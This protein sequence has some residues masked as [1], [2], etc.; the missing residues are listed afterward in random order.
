MPRLPLAVLAAFTLCSSLAVA[1]EGVSPGATLTLP[2]CIGKALA[3]HPGIDAARAA[4]DAGAA[5]LRASRAAYYPG[6]SSFA[7]YQR[8][9]RAGAD[10][11]TE[12]ENQYRAGIGASY[13]LLDF[14]RRSE[15]VRASERALAANR[16]ELR[17]YERELTFDVTAAYLEL[18][19]AERERVVTEQS[20]RK[21]QDHLQ[22]AQAFFAAGSKPRYDV[23]KAEIDLVDEQL[24]LTVASNSVAL[25]RV[26]LAELVGL[27]PS[28]DWTVAD[29]AE[30]AAAPAPLADALSSAAASR[31][32]L[33]AANE[34]A[35][36][37]EATL[38]AVRAQHRPVLSSSGS[39]GFVGLN[40]PLHREWDA[41]VRVDL[42]LFSGF[43]ITARV[44]EAKA[45]LAAARAEVE[46]VR[47]RVDAEVR[48]AVLRLAEARA[49]IDAAKAQ[50]RLAREALEL[51]NLRYEAGVGSPIEVTD[52]LV[53]NS[54]A[55][56]SDV[57]AAIDHQLALAALELA[58][59]VDT[60]GTAQP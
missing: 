49:R 32:E 30:P 23:T 40:F 10:V 36:A 52:A 46:T 41:G 15:T 53:A 21:Y 22:R 24:A 12:S 48:G 16:H 37:A 29:P 56:L 35:A 51:A 60:R 3:T 54:A 45:A 43:Q 26:A 9:G 1:Q 19:R 27:E 57:R 42:S 38:A 58:M 50:V 59:G 18:L 2:E 17:Q 28:G 6:L 25:A 13:V 34:R 5:R 39:Y 33:L 44:A 11:V 47:R 20:V 4:T 55:G 7:S 14:G 8:A 31:A